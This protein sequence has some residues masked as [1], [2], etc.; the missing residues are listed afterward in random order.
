MSPTE[1]T[2][3]GLRPVAG[4]DGG[5]HRSG[6]YIQGVDIEETT[7]PAH[8]AGSVFSFPCLMREDCGRHLLPMIRQI[9]NRPDAR[10]E[11][12]RRETAIRRIFPLPGE[13]I[14]CIPVAETGPA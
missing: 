12:Q 13:N 8:S 3:E 7:L 2:K 10:G 4:A 14:P 6:S 9:S 5:G 11:T 1:A